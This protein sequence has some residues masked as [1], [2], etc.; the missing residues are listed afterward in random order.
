MRSHSVRVWAGAIAIAILWAYAARASGIDHVELT[1]T[2][3]GQ[4]IALPREVTVIANR[5]VLVVPITDGAFV[6]PSETAQAKTAS[7]IFEVLGDRVRLGDLD[8]QLFSRNLWR[9]RLADRRFEGGYQSEVPAGKDVRRICM[10]TF[11]SLGSEPL[12][13]TI[14]DCRTRFK[15]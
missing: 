14:F 11:D 12:D 13:M 1:I 5:H 15:H 6:V 8:A 3:N 7:L 10:V 9:I 4:P 2:H